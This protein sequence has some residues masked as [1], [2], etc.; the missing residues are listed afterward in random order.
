MILG[1]SIA[2]F[3]TVHVLIS[4]FAILAGLVVLGGMIQNVDAGIWTPLFLLTV[5]L[6]AITGFPIPPFGFDPPRAIGIVLLVLVAAAT[7]AFYVFRLAA[8]WRSIYVFTATAAL[9]L[10]SFVA[11]V[12]AFQK[13]A[14]LNALAPT[15]QEPPFAVA[16]AVLLGLFIAAAVIARKKFRLVRPAAD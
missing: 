3:T 4:L 6:T 10:D 8:P 12:Q 5:A 2:T 7:G 13:V 9:Y 16:Q 15:Q 14:F 11:V 1:L